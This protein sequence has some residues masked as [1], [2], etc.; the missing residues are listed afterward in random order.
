MPE[1][2]SVKITVVFDN[3]KKVAGLKSGWG[4]SCFIEGSG[5]PRIL[6]DTGPDGS[7]LLY[8]MAQLNIDP[9][10]ID[11]IFISHGHMDHA[12]GLQAVLQLNNDAIVYVPASLSGRLP[13]PRFIPVK[14]P[15]YICDDA[16]STGEL[17]GIEQSLVL[18][19]KRSL[20]VVTGCSHPGLKEIIDTA[21][22][23]GVVAN[24]IGGFHGFNDLSIL[25]DLSYICPCHCTARKSEI[26]QLFPEKSVQCGAGMVIIL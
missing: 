1:L 9:R 25:A 26:K 11:V 3:E 23:H 21:S 12:G 7:S 15:I 16:F 17:A 18:D 13:K 8:N 20:T 14:E 4:F 6:F 22:E 19:D 24:I 10:S 2:Y 5:L